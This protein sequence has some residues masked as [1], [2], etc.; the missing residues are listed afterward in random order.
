MSRQTKRL[1]FD[2]ERPF[3]TFAV[4]VF[5][6]LA[7]ILVMVPIFSYLSQEQINEE[8]VAAEEEAAAAELPMFL[9][10]QVNR[11]GSTDRFSDR[12]LVWNAFPDRDTDE[13]VVLV[14]FPRGDASCGDIHAD[15]RSLIE[16]VQ[17]EIT[18]D[19]DQLRLG[20]YYL[21]AE[22]TPDGLHYG[23]EYDRNT[24]ETHN[25]EATDTLVWD[26]AEIVTMPS[27]CLDREDWGNV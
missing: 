7:T 6:V 10:H 4:V 5:S 18:A 26:D 19:Y 21:N 8:R 22:G 9:W 20:S 3:W 11:L 14:N 16:Y 1:S 25:G 15:H 17:E 24:V 2:E 23:V 12:E 13:I 27:H